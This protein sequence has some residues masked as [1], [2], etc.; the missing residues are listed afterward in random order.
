MPDL[1]SELKKLENMRF[2]DVPDDEPIAPGSINE[3]VFAYIKAT[4]GCTCRQIGDAV[5]LD[6]S[7]VSTRMGKMYERKLVT[8]TRIGMSYYYK[9]AASEYPKYDKMEALAKAQ[10]VRREK[11]LARRKAK[12]RKAVV[13]APKTR[14]IT[15]TPRAVQAPTDVRVLLD[16]LPIA[17]ARALYD[18]LRKIFGG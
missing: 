1:H 2:D 12:E 8:R 17:T 16:T 15:P 6:A 14:S 5:G 9:A 3:R 18:E 13:S 7:D 10:A 11:A 4:P